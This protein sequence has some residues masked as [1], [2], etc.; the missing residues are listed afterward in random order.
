MIVNDFN[1][2]VGSTGFSKVITF[3]DDGDDMVYVFPKT[4]E[5]IAEIQKKQNAEKLHQILKRVK[6]Y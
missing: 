1:N 4:T 6:T 3:D 2:K 5:F